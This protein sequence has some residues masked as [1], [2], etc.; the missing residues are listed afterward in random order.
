[1]AYALQAPTSGHLPGA[2]A[3]GA[4]GSQLGLPSPCDALQ[5]Q[6][7]LALGSNTGLPQ[8]GYMQQLLPPL[9]AIDDPQLEQ[10]QQQ[11]LQPDFN[12]AV[13]HLLHGCRVTPLCA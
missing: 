6:Q 9:P 13:C 8:L 5:Q 3:Q 11:Q 2:T 7:A 12:D 4:S 1:M 10:Q